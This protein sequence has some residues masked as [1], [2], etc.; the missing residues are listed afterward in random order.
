[1]LVEERGGLVD[2]VDDDGADGELL[3][4]ECHPSQRV[5][6]EVRAETAMLVAVVDGEASE[7]RDW[8]RVVARHAFAGSLGRLSVVEL[9]GEQCVVADHDAGI[10]DDE[11][12]GSVPSLALP[13]VAL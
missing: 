11:R 2:G 5:L 7:D 6:Q 4:G 8:D 1:M 10:G 12:A 9:A 13:G 3:R